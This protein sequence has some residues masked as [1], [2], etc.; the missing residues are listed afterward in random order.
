MGRKKRKRSAET[1]TD[2]LFWWAR[3]PYSPGLGCCCYPPLAGM[4]VDDP[5]VAGMHVD[6][7]EATDAKPETEFDRS[8]YCPPQG[9]RVH[10]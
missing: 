10:E 3:R 6:S 5:P 7:G 9:G 8:Y 4:Y 1:L 2:Y